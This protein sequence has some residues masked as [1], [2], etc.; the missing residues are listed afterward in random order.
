[1]FEESL[2]ESTSLLRTHNRWPA[3][4]SLAAQLLL[5]ATLILTL[6]L[7]HPAMLPSAQ[8]L[9]A[10]L[11]PPPHPAPP[12]PIRLKPQPVSTTSSTPSPT[13]LVTAHLR[14]LLHLSGPAVDA[15]PL[16]P[17]DLSL[18]NAA[19][20]PELNT[21]APT[22]PHVAVAPA[23]KSAAS[24]LNISNGVSIGLLLAPIRPDYPSIARITHTQ[25]VV[26]IEA[27]ISRSGSIESAHA[28]SGPAMLQPSALT[29]V[30]QARYHP[31]L[32]N[33]QP[34]EV[35]TTITVNFRLGG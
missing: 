28:L 11:T 24:P 20:P 21:S 15:P 6:P 8:S 4:L 30:R 18:P 14:D 17:I 33:G 22:G 3:L 10:I 31:F 9:P 12:P 13:N 7:L 34:T 19:L 25:G 26:V 1:M 2:V 29:A 16:G 5:A 35:Q 32:L 23:A 27:I